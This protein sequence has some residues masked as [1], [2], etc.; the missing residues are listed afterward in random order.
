MKEKSPA[1]STILLAEHSPFGYLKY[2][3]KRSRESK[4]RRSYMFRLVIVGYLEYKFSYRMSGLNPTQSAGSTSR[5]LSKKM[6]MHLPPQSQ[7]RN[8][9]ACYR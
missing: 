5:V 4:A 1:T 7:Y 6:L 3:S 2:S 8:D 9:P